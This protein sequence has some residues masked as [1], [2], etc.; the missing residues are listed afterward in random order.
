MEV[1]D[2]LESHMNLGLFATRCGEGD[3]RFSHTAKLISL[4]LQ[5]AGADVTYDQVFEDIYQGGTYNLADL[6]TVLTMI[7]SAIFPSPVK[8]SK[9]TGKKTTSRSKKAKTTRGKAS[10]T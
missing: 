8:K 2:R 7:F 1:I 10:T 6:R 5:E 3:I 4:L 9:P